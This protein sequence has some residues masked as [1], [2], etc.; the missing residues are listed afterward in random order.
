[1]TASWSEAGEGAVSGIQPEDPLR[2][3]SGEVLC[4]EHQEA[5]PL[6]NGMNPLDT[7]RCL[8]RVAQVQHLHR[9]RCC[10]KTKSNSGREERQLHN[11]KEQNIYPQS[12]RLSQWDI[13]P[14]GLLKSCDALE[15]DCFCYPKVQLRNKVSCWD[16]S[17]WFLAMTVVTETHLSQW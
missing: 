14:S 7:Q 8:V 10:Q 9:P 11:I 6:S 17:R 13:E 4:E 16:S 12:L 15:E 5:I 2:N 1:M 3:S